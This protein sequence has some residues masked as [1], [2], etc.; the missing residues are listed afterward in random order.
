MKIFIK[1]IF[2]IIVL[3]T[4]SLFA[5]VPQAVD[6]EE[7]QKLLGVDD[8][9]QMGY[10]VAIDGDTMV[11]SAFVNWNDR[12]A[13]VYVYERGESGFGVPA[14]LTP[15][16]CS[17]IFGSSVA[18][19]GDTIVVGAI[20]AN[21]EGWKAKGSAYI[22]EKPSSGWVD[23]T[24][25]TAKLT[26]SDVDEGYNFGGSVAIDG[27]TV[28]IGAKNSDIPETDTGAA[29]VFTKPVTSSWVDANQTAKL[30]AFD[31][32]LVDYFGSSVAIDGDKILIG[33]KGAD[34]RTDDPTYDAD[35]NG[36]AY[37]FKKPVDG[38]WVDSSSS[39]KIEP[40]V[41]RDQG[42]FG[43]SV[44]IDGTTIAVGTPGNWSQGGQYLLKGALYIFEENPT[45]GK[46]EQK[47][48][49][50]AS[51]E[52][53]NDDFAD[54]EGAIDIDNNMVVVGARSKMTSEGQL[55]FATA[56]LYKKPANGWVNSVENSKIVS[57]DIALTDSFGGSVSI[58]GDTIVIGAYSKNIVGNGTLHDGAT[59]VFKADDSDLPPVSSSSASPAIIMYLLN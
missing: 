27:D 44:A 11:V 58:S 57:S 28:V 23:M 3:L 7:V 46:Y 54:F 39:V 8:E 45:N 32:G 42:W 37:L 59:Y 22:F 2:L 19:S 15:T 33:A 41:I 52:E 13:K 29:Y 48:I 20:Y 16:N 12:T 47:A 25:Q 31:G 53:I 30:T 50:R 35:K 43:S 17:E 49:L 5:G 34:H 6:V 51:D 40:D 4:S 9:E 56:Y 26:A 1:S 55:T 18:I 24:Q 21:D 38:E 10:S 36:A 14:I